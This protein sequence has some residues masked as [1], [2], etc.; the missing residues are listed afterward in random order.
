MPIQY[1]GPCVHYV[2]IWRDDTDIN[3]KLRGIVIIFINDKINNTI[4]GYCGICWKIRRKK[5]RLRNNRVRLV[6][7]KAAIFQVQCKAYC[8]VSCAF[9]CADF[10]GY[11]SR[12]GN[13][14]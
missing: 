9:D 1:A 7:A 11:C 5:F 6:Y 2:V 13:G 12:L 10:P 3:R 8:L 4:H 14:A